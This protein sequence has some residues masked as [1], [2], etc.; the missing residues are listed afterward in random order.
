MTFAEMRPYQDKTVVLNLA[1]G[2]VTTAKISFVVDTEY[3]DII[4]YVV[5]TK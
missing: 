5:S 1:D 4:V 2:E 3:E